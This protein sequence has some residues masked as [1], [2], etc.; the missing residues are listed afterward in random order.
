MW[1]FRTLKLSL[2]LIALASNVQADPFTTC[3]SK[4]FLIQDS[5]AQIY[6][7]NLVT[8]QFNLLSNDLGTNSKINGFGFNFHDNNLY[9]WGY[10]WR[11]LVRIGND[12]QA[13]PLT[14][15]NKPNTDFY[16]GDVALHENAY[17]MYR[18]GS[19]YG[20][21]KINLDP[22]DENYL[23]A[24][25]VIDGS[26][27]F[28]QIFDLAFHPTDGFAYSVDRNGNLYRIDVSNGSASTLG[29]V[30][31]IGTFGA[32][33]FDVDGYFYISR[34]QDGQ[35][36]RIDMSG[37]IPVTE[38]FA[39]GPSS[40]NNDGARCAIAPIVDDSEPP[41]TDFG[42]APDSYGTSLASNGARHAISDIYLG[43]AVDAEYDAFIYPLSDEA[44]AN[45]EDGVNF[46]SVFESGMDSLI[47]VSVQGAGFLNIWV[48]W[49]QS[50][51]FTADEQLVVD[52][53][54]D[55]GTEAFLVQTPLNAIS[56]T[57]WARVRY[58]S[59]AV[60]SPTGG[61]SDGEV[62]DYQV[63]V[64]NPGYTLIQNNPYFIAFEDKW[65]EKGDYDFNDVV[66][67]LES[68]LI[69]TADNEVKLLQLDG[70]LMAMGASYHNGF[71]IQL[72]GIT[73]DDI[74]QALIRFELNGEASTTDLLEAGTDQAV[75]KI[76]DD[77]WQHVNPETGCWFYKTQRNCNSPARFQFSIRLP[78]E[79]G[80]HV[81]N[82]P[83][84]PYN[85]FIFATPDTAHGSMFLENPG[86]GL[87]I[88][89]KNQPPTSLVNP[90]YFGQ[91]DDASDS[92]ANQYYQTTNG[93]PWGIAV[94]VDD[95]ETWYHPLE[96]VEILRAYPLFEG[97][98]TSS[99]TEN[100][101]WFTNSHSIRSKTYRY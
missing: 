67:R 89:L 20:L 95:T 64:L 90:D 35:I 18:G 30:G 42:D 80:I 46:V 84:S 96:W 74:N 49:D 24:N 41:T 21:Y 87:E 53:S 57:T 77:L 40:N 14:V 86:R 34:N 82:F 31:E 1:H 43:S 71:A 66:I 52:R 25:R 9:G 29:N 61:V 60:T 78:F 68:S 12:F 88:H 76:S 79:A 93:L 4:A 7:V 92:N 54:M 59:T 6:G 72:N 55:T 27:L 81:T 17:Y 63:T 19:S 22:A 23:V 75:L 11:T 8:G 100:Q 65:P 48:D 99:G 37:N 44:S 51:D 85:P 33:Y 39:F 2:I 50:G 38:L 32:V 69:L 62:E 97:Y 26:S 94:G 70:Q 13:E 15:I 98:A 58:S 3:P 47:Q 91:L 5:V 56:G 10:E 45:D 101:D 28:L 16:V 36:F 83:V 73:H